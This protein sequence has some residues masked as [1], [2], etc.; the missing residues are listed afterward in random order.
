MTISL[1]DCI[2]RLKQ[3]G[4]EVSED[5]KAVVQ[6]ELNKMIAYTINLCNLHSVEQLPNVLAPRVVDRVCSEF[7]FYK[8]NTGQLTDFD[9]SLAT[10]SI[11]QGDTKVTYAVGQEGN[12]NESRF[13]K[14]VEYMQRG[15]DKWVCKYRVIRW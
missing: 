13:D 11:E 4:Y 5:D 1:D 7:L 10:K 2:A 8:K 14:A 3:F 9:Y 15:Y 12:T 6:F